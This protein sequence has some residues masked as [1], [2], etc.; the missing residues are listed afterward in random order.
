MGEPAGLVLYDGVC[1]LC[2]RTVAW[3]LRIDRAERLQFAP[4]EGKTAAEIL[5][6]HPTVDGVESLVFVTAVGTPEERVST[7]STAVLDCLATVG[8]FWWLV[9]WKRLVPRSLRD[10]I[11]DWVA[12]HR[13]GWF[14]KYESCPKPPPDVAARFLD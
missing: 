3:L 11:Y 10:W 2:N 5:A 4:L 14:G 12:R 13:Y 7:R 9:S 6:R 8:G 1:A